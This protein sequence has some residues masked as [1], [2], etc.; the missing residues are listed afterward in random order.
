[1]RQVKHNTEAMMLLWVFLELFCTFLKNS[2]FNFYVYINILSIFLLSS[3]SVNN[4]T[5]IYETKGSKMKLDIFINF[6]KLPVILN[7]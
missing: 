5:V 1:M 4:I 3:H 7:S 6:E 2:F